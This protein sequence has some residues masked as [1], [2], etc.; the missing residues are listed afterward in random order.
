MSRIRLFTAEWLCSIRKSKQVRRTVNC[1]HGYI[2]K[3]KLITFITF[4]WNYT[5]YGETKLECL[6]RLLF[7]SSIHLAFLPAVLLLLWSCRKLIYFKSSFAVSR[8][9]CSI[10]MKSLSAERKLAVVFY[11]F[12][13]SVDTSIDRFL[14]S[15]FSWKMTKQLFFIWTFLIISPRLQ[16]FY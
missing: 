2:C 4:I 13:R 5:H 7:L 3:R 16:L 9:Y 8:D 12:T 10:L 11:L 14:V 15:I 6:Q 1:H